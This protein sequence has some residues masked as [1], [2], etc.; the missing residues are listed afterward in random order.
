MTRQQ[1]TREL[2]AAARALASWGCFPATDGNMSAR[3]TNEKSLV[4]KCGTAKANL[5][6]SDF[7]LQDLR[8]EKGQG[9]STEWPMHRA[10]FLARPEIN[11]VLHA[12][13]PFLTA[14]AVA[15]RV[16]NR[17]LLSEAQL[18]LGEIILVPYAPPGSEQL[19]QSLIHASKAAAVYLLAN[20]GAVAVGKSVQE[21][22]FVL[23]R[24]ESLARIECLSEMLGGGRLLPEEFANAT[25]KK[26]VSRTT[27]VTKRTVT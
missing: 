13:A 1:V 27:R 17:R 12:H 8:G 19:A 18:V 4:T 14:Y 23:E 16:P 20:H 15:H 2:I 5:R 10:L 7:V 11:C 3:V 21:T 9:V 25:T 24:A 22:R 26:S 6:A